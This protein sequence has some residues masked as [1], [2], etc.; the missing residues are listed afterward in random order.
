MVENEVEILFKFILIRK[1]MTMNLIGKVL[2]GR[3]INLWGGGGGGGGGGVVKTK[4]SQVPNMFPKEFQ[5]AP[6]F[7][8]ICF[9]KCCPPFTYI[10]GPK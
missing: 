4:S 3:G 9:V 2:L 6:Q 7:Y 5:I 1:C 8:P 10:I